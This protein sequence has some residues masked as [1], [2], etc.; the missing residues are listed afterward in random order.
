MMENIMTKTLKLI[1]PCLCISLFFIFLC[2]LSSMAKS[3]EKLPFAAVRALTK[4]QILMQKKDVA[5]AA[6]VLETFRSKAPKGFKPGDPDPKGYQHYQINFALGNCYL[7]LNKIN[8]A[9]LSYEAALKTKPDSSYAWLNLAKCYYDTKR[10]KK[11]GTGFLKGYEFSEKKDPSFLYFSAVSFMAGGDNKK[12][13]KI[14]ERLVS[15]HNEQ[16]KLEWKELIAQVYLACNQPVKALPW[17]EE[18]C[19]EAKGKKK[20]QWQEMLLH[21]Y[22]ALNMKKKA[23]MFAD[24][25]TREDPLEPKWWKGLFRIYLS[26]NRYK[27][28]LTPLTIYTYMTSPSRD[29][30][31]LL[32]DINMAVGIPCRAA[33]I[34]EKILK[35]NAKKGTDLIDRLIQAYIN[36]H[37]TP[38]AIK[39]ID[40]AVIKY[41]GTKTHKFLVLKG[42]LLMQQEKYKDAFK[43]FEMAAKAG[44]NRGKSYMMAAYA[45]LNLEDYQKAKKALQKAGKYP[46]QRRK[47][48]ELL[49]NL[50]AV[51]INK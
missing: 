24:K 20:K 47:A 50:Q 5:G 45:A 7:E 15:L 3:K 9:V 40:R 36:C 38:M 18:I 43:A 14:L 27:E 31:K 2:P 46:K 39:T 22:L 44:G 32:A 42:Q 10:Y 23:L 35:S 4:A 26:E 12:S 49:T 51:S 30:Q 17:I 33:P 8:K 41:P 11:A 29:E 19:K 6:K 16:I 34:Y 1:V 13:I 25:L 21:Q 28:A 48:K 37:N